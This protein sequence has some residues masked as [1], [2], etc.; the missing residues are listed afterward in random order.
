MGDLIFYPA[1]VAE[2]PKPNPQ[3]MIY[4]SIRIDG[5]R[6]TRIDANVSFDSKEEK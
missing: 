2:K 6:K 5:H 3:K 4:L 1:D